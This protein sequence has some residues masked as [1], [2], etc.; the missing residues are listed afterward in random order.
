MQ[1]GHHEVIQRCLNPHQY[2]TNEYHTP[3]RRFASLLV[4]L[5][6][7]VITVDT[8]QVERLL[9]VHP[10]NLHGVCHYLPVHV[11]LVHRDSLPYPLHY[12]VGPPLV[13]A[14]GAQYLRSFTL[15][16][17]LMGRRDARSLRLCASAFLRFCRDIRSLTFAVLV[18]SLV[19]PRGS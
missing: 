5:V 10:T 4:V 16:V 11:S 7:L 14:R 3:L 8:M 17:R 13:D 2:H 1:Q 6:W 12:L 19:D 18:P 9:F 15:A